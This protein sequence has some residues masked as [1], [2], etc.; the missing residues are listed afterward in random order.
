MIIKYLKGRTFS[1][2]LISC[3]IL[4]LKKLLKK[5]KEKNLRLQCQTKLFDTIYVEHT[6]MPG[7]AHIQTSNVQL[8]PLFIKL[9]IL[10]SILYIF[11]S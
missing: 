1:K 3:K 8:G 10:S 9:P 11:K 6:T 2:F 4:F 7:I 5:K